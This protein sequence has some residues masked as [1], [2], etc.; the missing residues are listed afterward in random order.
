MKRT[1]SL[2][3]VYLPYATQ[4]RILRRVQDQLER[5]CYTYGQAR[6]PDIVSREGWTCPESVEL[7]IWA[8]KLTAHQ[9]R[10]NRED[11]ENLRKPL[12]EVLESIARIRHTAV[13][14]LPVTAARVDQYLSDAEMLSNLLGDDTGSRSLSR[15]RRQLSSTIDELK[16]N[17]DV[18]ESKLTISQR[19]IA[20]ERSALDRAEAE[21]K[22]EML[23]QDQQYQELA[24]AHLEKNISLP[25]EVEIERGTPTGHGAGSDAD[26]DTD[27][28][29]PR[30]AEAHRAGL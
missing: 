18:L 27:I 5:T 2:Y 4:H 26:L 20:A 12:V 15:I 1:S 14:R 24:A 3:P 8:R 22:E 28:E 25:E 19:R 6:L 29:F 16:R 30:E 21:A 13:H 9:D 10:L 17:K 11:L 7:H 23:K